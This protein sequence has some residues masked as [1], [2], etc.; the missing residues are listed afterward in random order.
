VFK[1]NLYIKIKLVSFE[2]YLVWLYQGW[3]LDILLIAKMLP[4][5]MPYSSIDS[6]AY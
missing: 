5:K 3:H 4:F 6:M 1:N 2:N